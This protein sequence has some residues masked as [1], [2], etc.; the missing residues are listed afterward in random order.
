[1][2]IKMILTN[3]F[4]IDVRVYKE[5]KYLVSIGHDVEIICWDKTPE[6]KLPEQETID[7]IKV[8]RVKLAS[9]AGTGAK[10]LRPYLRFILACRH[11][12]KTTK[13]DI[14][15]C[16]DLDGAIIG[17]LNGKDF[18]F[19][20][21]EFYDKGN[22]LKKKLCHH[23]V[24]ML[25]KRAKT[26]ICVTERSIKAYGKGYEDK[27]YLLKNYCDPSCFTDSIKSKSDKLRVSY[28][29]M[30]RNQIAEFTALFEAV[31]DLEQVVVNVYGGGVDLPKLKE[32]ER[33]Y[34]NVTVHGDY[35]GVKESADIYNN[36]D[37]SYIAYNCNNP[38]YQG[39]FEPVKLYEAIFTGTP[40]LATEALNPGSVA[41]NEGIGIAVN[42]LNSD[43]IREAILKFYNNKDFYNNCIRNMEKLKN[44]YNWNEHVK[45]LKEIY[46]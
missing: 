34:N 35:D 17:W 5:A 38:N 23:M 41:I 14:L 31:A 3:P 44:K 32:L 16:H 19:D 6:R 20:M 27:F 7:G 18:N 43:E 21:H 1:M 36:T 15:H 40:I 24:I 8:R 11:Y 28:I 4:S 22:C 2:T 39:D 37:V 13:Y 30:V 9:K 12:L 33:K 10:Q 42:T 25:V 45:I 46:R 29:G 26:I